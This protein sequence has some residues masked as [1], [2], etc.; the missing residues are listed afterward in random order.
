MAASLAL[1]AF[2]NHACLRYMRQGSIVDVMG[3]GEPWLKAGRRSGTGH[4]RTIRAAI[5]SV[6]T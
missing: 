1:N 2:V 5:L 6:R 3:D 4:V